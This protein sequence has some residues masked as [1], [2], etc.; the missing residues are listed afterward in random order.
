VRARRGARRARR[1]SNM[2]ST[3][4]GVRG[5]WRL[6]DFK[7][8]R[9]QAG[10]WT[11]GRAPLLPRPFSAAARPALKN[12]PGDR[13]RTPP[14]ACGLA[15]S[16]LIL[17]AEIRARFN[18]DGRLG[19]PRT[20]GTYRRSTPSSRTLIAP[21]LDARDAF[22]GNIYDA[23]PLLKRSGRILS[24]CVSHG[25]RL[26]DLWEKSSKRYSKHRLVTATVRFRLHIN[27]VLYFPVP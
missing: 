26:R 24:R 7:P 6:G 12:A 3:E 2:V 5:M 8:G 23:L 20:P 19:F 1:A 21:G 22:R 10:P 13:E 15:M 9:S 11:R 16:P 18:P 4:Q 27:I 25:F 14:H 17:H